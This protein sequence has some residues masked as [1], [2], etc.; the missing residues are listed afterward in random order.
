MIFSIKKEDIKIHEDIENKIFKMVYYDG[1]VKYTSETY[2]MSDY[3]GKKAEF[4]KI[5]KKFKREVKHESR[6][7]YKVE[8]KQSV[9][10]V[11]KV[12]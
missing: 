11:E 1:N 10:L 8:E 12:D 7:S 6:L 9:S 3:K 2:I 5:L 4:D